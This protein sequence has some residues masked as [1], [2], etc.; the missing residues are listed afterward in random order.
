MT[1]GACTNPFGPDLPEV[2]QEP[3]PGLGERPSGNP[4][5]VPDSVDSAAAVQPASGTGG[6]AITS[7][8]AIPTTDESGASTSKV[9]APTSTSNSVASAART[10]LPPTSAG[11]PQSDAGLGAPAYADGRLLVVEDLGV[12]ARVTVKVASPL[13]KTL[14]EQEVMGVGV[15]FFRSGDSESDYQ[16][17]ADGGSDG[18]RAFLQTPEGFVAFPG[19]FRLSGDTLQFEVPWSSLGGPPSGSVSAFVD[20]GKPAVG[21]VVTRTQDLVPDTGKAELRS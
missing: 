1:T 2:S 20:W 21:G 8:T 6:A 13:P 15:D 19:D 17:F 5:P 10:P 3:L 16:L 18:W 11:D 9:S 7:P 12:R 14:A 4:S